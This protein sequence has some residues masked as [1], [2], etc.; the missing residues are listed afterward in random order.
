MMDAITEQEARAM[1]LVVYLPVLKIW[2][3]PNQYDVYNKNEG[4]E[5][6]R[7]NAVYRE[8]RPSWLVKT[9]V[10]LIQLNLR[11]RVLEIDWSDTQLPVTPGLGDATTKS[12]FY[13]HAWTKLKAVE[14]LADV[15]GAYRAAMVACA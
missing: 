6:T 4:E 1:F 9:P 12:E 10:G 11:K 2:R 7:D 5:Y 3:L 13:I 8:S 15:A 14:Y